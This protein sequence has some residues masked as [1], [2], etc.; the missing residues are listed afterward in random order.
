MPMPQLLFELVWLLQGSKTGYSGI[1]GTAFTGL[2]NAFSFQLQFL[3]P[4]D[5]KTVTR[6]QVPHQVQ[7]L[8]VTTATG[9]NWS[10]ISHST[11]LKEWYVKASMRVAEACFHRGLHSFRVLILAGAWLNS[12]GLV[13]VCLVLVHSLSELPFHLLCPPVI[14][15]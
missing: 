12:G 7:E 3:S 13:V 1:T 11:L 8:C 10:R 5:N 6:I 9:A 15:M 2:R 4:C 14:V